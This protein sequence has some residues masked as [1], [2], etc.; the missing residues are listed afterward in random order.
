MISNNLL[1]FP[2]TGTNGA[3]QLVGTAF[4]TTGIPEMPKQL[5]PPLPPHIQS[6]LQRLTPDQRAQAYAKMF[7][8]FQQ[9]Q[10][11]QQS[12]SQAPPQFQQ[13]QPSPFNMGAQNFGS[14]GTFNSGNLQ[15]S[16]QPN[17]AM[18]LF[19]QVGGS[20]LPANMGL[21]PN[22]MGLHHRTPSGNLMPQSANMNMD[23]MNPDILQS[24]MA[25]RQI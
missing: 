25:R 5:I 10:Q 23:G 12:Q 11:Q 24:F 6:Q 9:Q 22:A 7:K 20:M 16:A 14:V 17:N 15:G 1:I 3:N 13:S 2:F 4:P 19:S 18:N 21:Q 8:Q